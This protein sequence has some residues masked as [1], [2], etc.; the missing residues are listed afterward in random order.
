MKYWIAKQIRLTSLG[1][2]GPPGCARVLGAERTRQL[3]VNK[4]EVLEWELSCLRS[5]REV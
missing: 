3:H 5:W 2:P 1:C 4:M